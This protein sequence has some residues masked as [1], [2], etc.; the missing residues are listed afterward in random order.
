[1]L[2][3]TSLKQTLRTPVKL[4]AYFL[5]AVLVAVLL[6]VGLN[7]KRSAQA[8][9]AAAEDCFT[10]IAVPE[11]W[12]MLNKS[13]T[14]AIESLIDCTEAE[15]FSEEAINLALTEDER[16]LYGNNLAALMNLTTQRETL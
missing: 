16:T 8:N 3:R 13:G 9:L 10:T 1:M 2:F 15:R 4:I 12:G 7:M 14:L 5:V 6:C 11:V